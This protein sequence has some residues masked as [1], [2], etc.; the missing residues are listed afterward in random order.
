MMTMGSSPC[1]L[2]SSFSDPERW[3]RNL[4]IFF[5]WWQVNDT[6]ALHLDLVTSQQQDTRERLISLLH[7]A[8]V[9]GGECESLQKETKARIMEEVRDLGDVLKSCVLA[10]G[11]SAHHA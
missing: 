5:L 6:I 1:F 4:L 7:K 9:R 8:E 11:T 2:P 3:R 10:E